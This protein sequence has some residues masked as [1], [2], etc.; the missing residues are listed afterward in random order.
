MDIITIKQIKNYNQDRIHIINKIKNNN[1]MRKAR[2]RYLW[3]VVVSVIDPPP[4]FFVFFTPH[5]SVVG[6]TND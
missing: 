3:V 2:S 4:F 5:R 6:K 1:E